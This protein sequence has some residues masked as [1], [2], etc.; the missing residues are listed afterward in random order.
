MATKP[1][2]GARRRADSQKPSRVRVGSRDFLLPTKYGH[3][4]KAVDALLSALVE[5]VCALGT[6]AAHGDDYRALDWDSEPWDPAPDDAREF[7]KTAKVGAKKRGEPWS[8]EREQVERGVHGSMMRDRA[9][10]HEIRQHT[11]GLFCMYWQHLDTAINTVPN[12]LPHLDGLT[13]Q[14]RGWCTRLSSTLRRIQ[15][16]CTRW[17]FAAWSFPPVSDFAAEMTTLHAAIDLLRD[18]VFSPV[19]RVGEMPEAGWYPADYYATLTDGY[20]YPNLL[21]TQYAAGKIEGDKPDGRWQYTLTSVV[22]A[23]P[24]QR[25]KLLHE[26]G[27]PV[28]MPSKAQRS[29]RKNRRQQK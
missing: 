19:G 22:R 4:P 29:A 18:G 12:V 24:T 7:I 8:E 26:D 20:L 11:P 23:N 9:R 6:L 21:R 28:A 27:T 25:D 5:V 17:Q 16:R 10:W 13:D 3:R 1:K 14:P 2:G 15:G